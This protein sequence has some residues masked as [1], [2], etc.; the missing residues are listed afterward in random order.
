MRICRDCRAYTLRDVCPRCGAATASPI[1]PRYSPED[2]HGRYRRQLKR[3][4]PW[5]TSS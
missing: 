3:E 4:G 2:R 5:K 1:P